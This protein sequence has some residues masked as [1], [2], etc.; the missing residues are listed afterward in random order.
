MAANIGEFK[1]QGAI[2]RVKASKTLLYHE[3]ITVGDIFAVTRSSADIGEVVAC[4]VEGVFLLSKKTSEAITQGKKV[5]LD[6]TGVIT[7]TAGDG[8][9]VGIAWSNETADSTTVEVKLNA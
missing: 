1:Q 6:A 4:D 2:I 3:L 9:P 8:S 5:Y 7:V